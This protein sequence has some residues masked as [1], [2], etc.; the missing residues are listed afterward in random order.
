[1]T[2]DLEGRGGYGKEVRLPCRGQPSIWTA[3]G[4]YAGPRISVEEVI[5]E[6]KPAIYPN[7]EAATKVRLQPLFGCE[8]AT[9]TQWWKREAE[10]DERLKDRRREARAVPVLGM[11]A[12]SSGE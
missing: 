3:I 4:A 6:V 12:W 1:M 9:A 10:P 8:F 11:T 5:C 2:A 7:P